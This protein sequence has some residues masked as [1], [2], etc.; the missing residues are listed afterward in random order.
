MERLEDKTNNNLVIRAKE[1]SHEHLATKAK[2]IQG[3]DKL[4]DLE[5]EFRKINQILLDRHV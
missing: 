4:Q 3:L 1:L 5:R 2:I